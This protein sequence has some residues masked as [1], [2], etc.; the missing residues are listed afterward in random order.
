MD[1]EKEKAKRVIVINLSDTEGDPP[2]G[3]GTSGDVPIEEL[4]FSL[5]CVAASMF[6]RERKPKEDMFE[7]IDSF[8]EHLSPENMMNED[9]KNANCNGCAER[10]NKLN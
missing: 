3:V 1:S 6:I 8:Y 9:C 4:L 10:K 2:V 5:V 7:L